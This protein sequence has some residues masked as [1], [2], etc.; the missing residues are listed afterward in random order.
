MATRRPV[1]GFSAL[2][3]TSSAKRK[4]PKAP[5]AAISTWWLAMAGSATMTSRV[6]SRPMPANATAAAMLT[7]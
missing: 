7:F 5:R 2:G 1:F 3:T 6:R 4:L